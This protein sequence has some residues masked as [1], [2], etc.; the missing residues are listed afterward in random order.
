M[1]TLR[2]V[3]LRCRGFG[4]AVALRSGD[5]E[6]TFG[7]LVDR[8]AR[9]AQ[10][11]TA[12]GLAPGDRVAVMVEDGIRALEPHLAAALAGLII[13]PVNARFRS[14]EV[15]YILR[16]CGSRA[17][18]HSSGVAPLVDALDAPDVV[19]RI[20]TGGGAAEDE[21]EAYE[22]I[23]SRGGAAA[24]DVAV[25]ADDLVM[26][27]YTSGTTGRPKGAMMTNRGAIAAVRSNVV[28]F[29]VTPYG[30]CAFSGSVSFT[31]LFWAF[32]VPHLFAGASIDFLQ[33]GLTMERWFERMERFGS[34]FTF[35]PTPYMDDFARHARQHPAVVERLA[36]VCHSASP[37][38]A[39]QRAAMVE[40]LGGAYVESYGMT[41]SLAAVAATTRPD[42]LAECAAEDRH[43]TI[44]RPLAP[45]DV[46]PVDADGNRLGPGT[47]GE[48]VI[49]SP[50]LFAG[51]W[52]NESA[53][54]SA[55]QGGRYLT[56]DLGHVDGRG[57]VYIDGRKADLIISGGMNVYPAEVEGVLATH[58]EVRE[59]AVVGIAHERW[60]EAVAAVVVS[61]DGAELDEETVIRFVGERL[62]SY[63]KPT[64][65]LFAETLPRNANL[66]LIKTELREMFA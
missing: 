9:L 58:P 32:I 19:V 5:A 6:R 53:S 55:L 11:L 51:Y 46:Y 48:L 59:A 15:E 44:G 37:A 14:A 39:A 13:V 22:A 42:A 16:D 21:S 8:A 49:E 26:I 36:G 2:D 35:V 45:A 10:H 3:V 56:G 33:P 64:R 12:A 24:P 62:A 28:A 38:S 7:E 29:R 31:A 17:V 54:A 60:G 25:S 23:V 18:L 4:D 63:K 41:E 52:N 47:V 57:F 43:A 34:T 20:D 61:V 66:K 65:V 50:S 27:G 1:N 40:V 30:A